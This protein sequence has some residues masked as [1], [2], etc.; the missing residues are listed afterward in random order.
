MY[1]HFREGAFGWGRRVACAYFEIC[2]G[3]WFPGQV[4]KD[5]TFIDVELV[6]QDVAEE[7][8]VH[9]A[10]QQGGALCWSR[11]AKVEQ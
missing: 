9:P 7:E 11:E 6:I 10:C 5:V 8:L 2:S 1:V 3:G 4:G